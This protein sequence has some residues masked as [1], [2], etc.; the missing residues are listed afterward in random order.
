MWAVQQVDEGLAFQLVQNYSFRGL[1][2]NVSEVQAVEMQCSIKQYYAC[3]KESAMWIDAQ[4]NTGL[5]YLQ[6]INMTDHIYNVI[7]QLS[8]NLSIMNLLNKK[9]IG[10]N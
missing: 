9:A 4:Y 10:D 5:R 7:D 3:T 2:T 1:S 8:S 6:G